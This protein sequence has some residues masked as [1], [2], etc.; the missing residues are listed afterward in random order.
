[1]K[2]LSVEKIIDSDNTNET[3][4]HIGQEHDNRKHIV[5]NTNPKS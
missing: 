3:E 4:S 5:G 2:K 1:M